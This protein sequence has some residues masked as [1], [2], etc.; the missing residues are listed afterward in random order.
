MPTI[1]DTWRRLPQAP[2][3][4]RVADPHLRQILSSMDTRIEA[5]LGRLPNASNQRAVAIT[6]L[7]QHAFS[8]PSSATKANVSFPATMLS[9]PKESGDITADEYNALHRDLKVVHAAL[10]DVIKSLRST[11]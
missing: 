10:S 6:E 8:Q 11:Q 1:P 7:K 5:L 9:K 2:S 3:T 4:Q